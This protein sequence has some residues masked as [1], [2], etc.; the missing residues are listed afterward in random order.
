MVF[1][2]DF[3]MRADLFSFAREERENARILAAVEN[4]LDNEGSEFRGALTSRPKRIR[5]QRRGEGL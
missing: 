1:M 3:Q 2:V 4:R 5:A